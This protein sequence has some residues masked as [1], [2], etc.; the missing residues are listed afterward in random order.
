VE[1]QPVNPLTLAERWAAIA[2]AK[3]ERDAAGRIIVPLKNGVIRFVVDMDGRGEGLGGI[4][5]KVEDKATLLAAAKDR[6]AMVNEEQVIIC[7][8][9]FN[10]G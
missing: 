2:A 9:R 7:G 4:D 3:L 6:G 1:I 5:V 8:V 10:L